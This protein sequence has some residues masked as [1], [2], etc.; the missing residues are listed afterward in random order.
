MR[1]RGILV[2]VGLL[3]AVCLGVAIIAARPR[4]TG[5]VY[6]GR[7][8][9]T[10][11]KIYSQVGLPHPNQKEVGEASNAVKQIGTNAL[12]WLLEQIRKNGEGD[13]FWWQFDRAAAALP[14]PTWR[15]LFRLRQATR[16]ELASEGFKLL[17]TNAA[18]ALPALRV[19][20]DNTN[21]PI[22]A[23][24]ALDACF[25]IEKDALPTFSEIITNTQHPRRFY[26]LVL[27]RSTNIST[28]NSELIR[29]IELC[30][31]DP[32]PNF[33]RSATFLLRN[34]T[35]NATMPSR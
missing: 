25:V 14:R 16:I 29:A 2:A 1:K 28:N 7:S 4:N 3:T 27:L 24:Y 21:T 6:Q 19:I 22:A 10:W 31:S 34:V 15:F 26:A 23:Y 11:L 9:Y 35:N 13:L 18:P 32:D 5:P 17:G 12:P 8:L 30:T 33:A 20:I